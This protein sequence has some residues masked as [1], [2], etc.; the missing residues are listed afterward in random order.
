MRCSGH[1]YIARNLASCASYTTSLANCR[2][3]FARRAS[4]AE[5]SILL[6]GETTNNTITAPTIRGRI[7][8]VCDVLAW[9]AVTVRKAR[10]LPAR[11]LE[12]EVPARLAHFGAN[13]I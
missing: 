6:G 3:E 12:R 11:V 8:D 10:G 13:G 4:Y 9:S 2:L 5:R 7:R 1:R